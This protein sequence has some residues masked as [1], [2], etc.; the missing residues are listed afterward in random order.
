MAKKNDEVENPDVLDCFSSIM[1]PTIMGYST[2]LL[3]AALGANIPDSSICNSDK[4]DSTSLRI[5][6]NIFLQS[7]YVDEIGNLSRRVG[8]QL[9][10]M[11]FLPD[12]DKFFWTANN[13]THV[14]FQ[15][16]QILDDL[17]ACVMPRPRSNGKGP[18]P[19]ISFNTQCGWSGC[20]GRRA[21]KL[22]G[23]KLREESMACSSTSIPNPKQYDVFFDLVVGNATQTHMH[24]VSGTQSRGLLNYNPFDIHYHDDKNFL[25]KYGHIYLSKLKL[26][27]NLEV[28]TILKL[29][30][31]DKFISNLS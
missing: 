8:F 1:D 30:H 20:Q 17:K 9:F 16:Q 22:V 18:M 21:M 26:I 24:L 7:I 2:N 31:L 5:P 28:R 13:F 14:G 27:T 3:S 6:L 12:S 4:I 23:L 11:R 25:N 10:L 15:G 29:R 19:M